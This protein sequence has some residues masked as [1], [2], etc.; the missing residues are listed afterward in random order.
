MSKFIIRDYVKEDYLKLKQ[1]WQDTG[2]DFPERGD[3]AQVIDLCLA[4][5]G[6]LLV[7]IDAKNELLTGSCWLTWDGRRLHFHHFAIHPD[8]QGQGNAKILMNEVMKYIKKTGAFVKLEVHKE[9][10]K[11]I[12][13][14]KKYGFFE[15]EDYLIMMKR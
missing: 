6:K 9:N 8:Y 15:F 5:G 2:L 1:L 3:D 10:H 4:L 11:A 14:Y 13:L 7:M 12:E